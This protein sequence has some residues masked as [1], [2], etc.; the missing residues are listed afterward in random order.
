[1]IRLVKTPMTA[2]QL[3]LN[4]EINIAVG[5]VLHTDQ[6]SCGECI[7]D[8]CIEFVREAEVFQKGGNPKYITTYSVLLASSHPS[9]CTHQR[10]TE[11]VDVFQRR[12]VDCGHVYE[13]DLA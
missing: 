4:Q 7:N 12:C 5:E 10:E 3:P 2:K 13:V 11:I 9:P 1:M 6:D 8:G